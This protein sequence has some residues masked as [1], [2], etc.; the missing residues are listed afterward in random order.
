[1]P[2]IITSIAVNRVPLFV[3]RTFKSASTTWF[4]AV[5][6]DPYSCEV[7]NIPNT[8]L[9][10]STRACKLSPQS[11]KR[12]WKTADDERATCCAKQHRSSNAQKLAQSSI[13]LERKRLRRTR[14]ICETSLWGCRAGREDYDVR[15][16]IIMARVITINLMYDPA[17]MCRTHIS[18]FHYVLV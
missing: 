12:S 16:Y 2:S 17:N 8:C 1:M 10:V 5:I 15:R 11:K 7:T 13:K 6:F 4:S 14:R 3:A 18:C 9:W